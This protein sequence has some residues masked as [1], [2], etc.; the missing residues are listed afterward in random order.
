MTA[1]EWLTYPPM[2]KADDVARI[3]PYTVKTIKK[4]WQQG[5]PK[6]PT[7]C[8]RKPYACRREDVRR[9]FERLSLARG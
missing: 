8:V 7:P 9:H 2:L 1:Q 6:V 5:S 4:M 3:Y